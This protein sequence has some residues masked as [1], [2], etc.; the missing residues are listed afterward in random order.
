MTAC[1]S[2]EA[3]TMDN[4]PTGRTL[5]I[6]GLLAT[7][8]L[9]W[10]KPAQAQTGACCMP[11]PAGNCSIETEADCALA[12]GSYR[13]DDTTC[14]TCLSACCVGGT[15]CTRET[16]ADCDALGGAF[17]GYGTDCLSPCDC[18]VV[19]YN[20]EEATGQSIDGALSGGEVNISGATLFVDFFE[21]PAIT[22][23]FNNP[24]Q[25]F[26]NRN[27]P[28]CPSSPVSFQ[29]FVDIDCSGVGD[30]VD[31][32][33]PDFTCGVP[34]EG[35]WLVNYRSVGSVEGFGEFIDFQLLGTIPTAIPSE[36]GLLNRRRYAN[37][38]AQVSPLN[39]CIADGDCDGF[40]NDESG[41]PFIQHSVD[42]SNTDSPSAW[43]SQGPT[44]PGS[45]LWSLKPTQSG[46]GQNQEG[47]HGVP[48]GPPP[49]GMPY[50]N[51]LPTLTRGA[52]SLNLNND[53]PT[54]PAPDA[55]T[56]FDTSIAWSPVCCI[57]NRGVG[58]ENIRYSEMQYV[59]VAGRLPTGEN[60]TACVRDVGSGT[61][62]AFANSINVDPSWCVGDHLGP[63]INTAAEAR[64]GVVIDT[65]GATETLPIGNRTQPTNCGGSGVMEDAVTDRR[66][67]IGFT[68]YFGA[69]RASEDTVSGRYEMLSVCKDIDGDGDGQPDSD[70]SADACD[71]G[72]ANLAFPAFPAIPG[73]PNPVTELAPAN[74]GFVRPSVSTVLDNDDPRCG[75]QI[76]SVQTFGTRGDP[77]SG[78]GGNV[79][80]AVANLAARDYIRNISDSILAFAGNPPGNENFNMPGESLARRFTPTAAAD[81]LPF[82]N[83]PT[84]IQAAANPG[85]VQT[86]QDYVRCNNIT[87][88]YTFG[89]VNSAGLVPRRNDRTPPNG[90]G[91]SY[92]D[93]SMNGR[94]WGWDN[95]A[96]AWVINVIGNSHRLNVR[97]LIAGDFNDDGARNIDDIADLMLAVQ[98]PRLFQSTEGVVLGAGGG[99]AGTP[100]EHDFVIPEGIGDFDGDGNF[101]ALDVRYFADGLAL[102][103]AT[104]LLD[105]KQGFIDVDDEWFALTAGNNYFGTL[106]H[107]TGAAYK[108]GDSRGDVAGS[109]DGPLRG[110]YPN[111]QDFLVNAA[112]IDYVHA[113]LGDWGFELDH[114]ALT[115]LSCDMDS[116]LIVDQRDVD[117][118]VHTILCTE[119]G[120]VDLDGDVDVVDQEILTGVNPPAAFPRP[121]GWADGDLNGDQ[122]VDGDDETILSANLGFVGPAC[123]TK[124]CG[125][126]DGDNDCDDVDLA[127]FADVL[128]SNLTTVALMGRA[129]LNND[130][131]SDALDV[132]QFIC[133]RLSGGDDAA[134]P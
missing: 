122:V 100:T 79:N 43:S 40:T 60:V 27:M 101:N 9:A 69:S 93:G 97:N 57:A 95:L 62:N 17:S 124:R 29:G 3:K 130:T 115:D 8:A 78:R 37:L 109:A 118:I 105:R 129:D 89:S 67:A 45:A 68:G 12:G 121:G 25:D 10:A 52:F 128:I 61:R 94:Y 54:T 99:V 108:S 58:R 88:T 65:P 76:G 11:L 50:S 72:P 15:D 7:A 113:N 131:R 35:H 90:P 96:M 117:Q 5:L 104:G 26:I 134:C 63:R 126:I 19:T 133:C 14:D 111:G 86:A 132:Q 91:G 55:D 116:N 13:G 114:A 41:I 39:A 31:Q 110:A 22:N 46:Y 53:P 70:C 73:C 59:F 42:I 23:D 123:L 80:P 49:L 44:A 82:I 102:D 92:N 98:D 71:G 81:G 32:L 83:N 84:D 21:L 127:L 85:F 107:S 34:F 103:P 125:D 75:Y 20:F 51:E 6:A 18:N 28:A 56:I 36:R 48:P 119:Y 77:E 30:F 24:D 2:R 74:G 64:L 47:S 1:F 38:G 4:Y 16:E 106:P 112:D 33:A 87:R 120:D 66:L